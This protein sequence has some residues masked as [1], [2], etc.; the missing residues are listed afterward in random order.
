MRVDHLALRTSLARGALSRSFFINILLL[1]Q[2]G[3]V[4]SRMADVI[5]VTGS[6]LGLLGL[7]V[8]S[9]EALCKFFRS[10]K[11]AAEDLEHHIA[12][13]Q[14]LKSTFARISDLERD[15]T[16]LDC[17]SKPLSSRLRECVV[18]LKAIEDFVK[19]LHSQL[20][21]GK[22]RRAWMKTKWAGMNQNERLEKY[23]ARIESYHMTFSLDLLLINT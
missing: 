4:Y 3:Q 15:F 13:L 11:E 12:A 8:K 9:C 14:A 16:N 19:P 20:L 10:F 7:A 23:M 21:N 5:S 22:T 2:I 17:V 1:L 6:V 18:D